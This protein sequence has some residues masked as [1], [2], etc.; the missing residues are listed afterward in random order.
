MTLVMNCMH[1]YLDTVFA[2]LLYGD[3][4]WNVGGFHHFDLSPHAGL[5]QRT[6]HTILFSELFDS[7]CSLRLEHRV[8][9]ANCSTTKKQQPQHV[10][11]TSVAVYIRLH[12]LNTWTD[13]SAPRQVD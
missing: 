5:I 8:N 6:D 1:A 12:W 3:Q 10:N 9:A 11:I 13:L 2:H 4:H 7:Y